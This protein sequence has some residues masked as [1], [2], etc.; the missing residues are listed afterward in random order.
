MATVYEAARAY[1]EAG[2]SLIPVRADATK[3]PAI[4][5]LP[6]VWD[7]NLRR[8]R[9]P[10][11]V[12][13]QRHPT[14][15]D[16]RDWFLD[17]AGE[18][19]IAILAGAISGNLEIIDLDRWDVV[20]PWKDLVNRKAP[21]LLRR[22]V[23]VRTPRPGLHV[24]FRCCVIGGNVKLARMPDLNQNNT[25]PKAT[26]EIKGEGGYCLAPPSPAACHPTGHCYS[27][28]SRTDLTAIPTITAAER[29]VLIDCARAL[30]CWD[31][32]RRPGY[33]RRRHRTERFSRPGDDFN[34]RADWADILRPHGWTWSGRGGDGSDN[35]TRP[36]KSHGTSATTNFANSDLLFVFSS[37]AD[38]FDELTGYTKF[39]AFTLLSHGG[40]FHAAAQALRAQGFGTAG[41]ARN[42]APFE[43][44]AHYRIPLNKRS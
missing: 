19:G 30:N 9:R 25:K 23:Q 1:L 6:R 27:V 22:L 42:A 43:R 4:E 34:R 44:Y 29:Q 36:G 26:I 28:I 5:L 40:N 3:M 33:V 14:R 7:G 37:N 10:W 12:Y 20:T 38:P 18:Y 35:W 11:G 8:Y 17:S 13:R 41:G 31:S 15:V 24:Y 2:L 21:G 39:H 16:L 32:P